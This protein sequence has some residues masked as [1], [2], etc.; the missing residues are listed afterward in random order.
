MMRA[1]RWLTVLFRH[2]PDA[3]AAAARGREQSCVAREPPAYPAAAD[4]RQA[5][6]EL[7]E[8]AWAA[9]STGLCGCPGWLVVA[10]ESY[11]RRELSER[12]VS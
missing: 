12:S 3:C 11:E 1:P 2:R 6:G 10:I 4:N 8:A 5:R 9:T 7:L